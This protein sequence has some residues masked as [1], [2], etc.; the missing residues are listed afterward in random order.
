MDLITTQITEGMQDSP[1]QLL[2]ACRLARLT[3]MFRVF[4]LKMIKAAKQVNR[5]YEPIT[6]S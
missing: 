4:R 5:L 1:T 2:R 6:V 3:R